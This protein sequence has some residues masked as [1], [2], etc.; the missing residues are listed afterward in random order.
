M[1]RCYI[2]FYPPNDDKRRGQGGIALVFQLEVITLG[3]LFPE[4]ESQLWNQY[5]VW[6]LPSRRQLLDFP[7]NL[8]LLLLLL[9]STLCHCSVTKMFCRILHF[10][11]QL[12]VSDSEKLVSDSSRTW[13]LSAL[14]QWHQTSD[15]SPTSF[16]ELVRRFALRPV[17]AVHQFGDAFLGPA[18]QWKCNMENERQSSVSAMRNSRHAV[19]RSF[20]SPQSIMGYSA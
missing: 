13:F 12:E 1:S 9:K 15:I 6:P 4:K 2:K 7:E 8:H 10:P 19:M 20:R 16:I 3:L 14:T 11:V 18:Y 5:Q 17:W